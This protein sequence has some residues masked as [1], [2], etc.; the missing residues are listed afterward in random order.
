MYI[1]TIPQIPGVHQTSYIPRIIS[2]IINIIELSLSN[3]ALLARDSRVARFSLAH[4]AL[5]PGI[6]RFLILFDDVLHRPVLGQIVGAALVEVDSFLADG[7]RETEG[8]AGRRE[9]AAVA[10]GADVAARS[11]ARGRAAADDPGIGLGQ[12][13]QLVGLLVRAGRVGRVGGG[14]RRRVRRRLQIHRAG[15]AQRVPAG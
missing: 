8:A 2:F 6:S 11:R 9:A 1:Y 5:Q 14:F 4:L 10:R 7:A 15:E 12:D 13:R 3:L